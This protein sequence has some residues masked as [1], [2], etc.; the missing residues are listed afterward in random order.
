MFCEDTV[1]TSFD[2]QSSQYWRYLK[3]QI[4][5]DEESDNQGS[6]LCNSQLAS[7]KASLFGVQGLFILWK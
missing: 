4:F 5:V 1:I 6:Y 3:I 7:S 2:P